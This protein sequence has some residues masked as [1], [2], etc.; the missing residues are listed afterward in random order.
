MV[1]DVKYDSYYTINTPVFL[2]R[3]FYISKIKETNI[4]RMPIY[5]ITIR[6]GLPT[7]DFLPPQ[8]FGN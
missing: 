6:L 7:G 4:N 8:P 2:Y 3:I 5:W 1:I